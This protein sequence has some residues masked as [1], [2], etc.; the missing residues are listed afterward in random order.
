VDVWW[1][2]HDGGLMLYLAHILTMSGTVWQG[3]RIRLFT[4]LDPAYSSSVN[5]VQETLQEM[6]DNARIN[7]VAQKP[8]LIDDGAL[9]AF[10]HDWTP[11]SK[12]VDESLDTYDGLASKNDA[13][14]TKKSKRR[15]IFDL[16]SAGMGGGGDNETAAAAAPPQK[17]KLIKRISAVATAMIPGMP[18]TTKRNTRR[19]SLHMEIGSVIAISSKRKEE[20]SRRHESFPHRKAPL[21]KRIS[22]FVT[23]GSTA[24]GSRHQSL[25]P[26]RAP[27]TKRISAF[28]TGRSVDVSAARKKSL[29]R[30]NSMMTSDMKVGASRA[31]LFEGVHKLKF[32]D[33]ALFE[34]NLESV[35]SGEYSGDGLLKAET[36]RS[37]GREEEEETPTKVPSLKRHPIFDE[38]NDDE[39]DDLDHMTAAQMRSQMKSNLERTP[40]D[41][42]RISTR[43]RM[44]TDLNSHIRRESSTS[45]LVVLNMPTPMEGQSAAKYMNYLQTLT[46]GIPRVILCHGTGREIINV[47]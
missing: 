16:V 2:V 21:M 12:A 31:E 19:A 44:W 4:V 29:R 39:D 43:T 11:R 46:R 37:A 17:S 34:K 28:V 9:K 22:A 20:A 3:H 5:D 8:I 35:E 15:S 25:E 14:T 1:V 32:S 42:R 41:S 10:S 6:V 30:T 24:S 27:L 18:A 38:D 7:A 40:S 36:T 33:K 45:A 13:R 47:E 23:G 26:K